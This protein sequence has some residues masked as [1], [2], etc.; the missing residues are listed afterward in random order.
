MTRSLQQLVIPAVACAALLLGT[1]AASAA[2]RP[3]DAP[4][5]AVDNALGLPPN[6]S[7]EQMPI[8]YVPQVAYFVE[9]IAAS[10]G[11]DSGLSR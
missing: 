10:L 2:A 6:A 5:T 4:V 3:M 1:G 8:E 11:V 7:L 9:A